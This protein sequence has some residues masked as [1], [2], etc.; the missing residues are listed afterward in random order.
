VNDEQYAAAIAPEIDRVRI[1]I[2]HSIRDHFGPLMLAAG[3]PPA[4]G[5]MLGML[6]NLGPDRVVSRAAVDR[7]FI[8]QA[9]G[10]VDTALDELAAAGVVTHSETD[11]ALTA[12]GAEVIDRMYAITREIV[13]EMWRD[14]THDFGELHTI[15]AKAMDAAA[16]TGGL[17]YSLMAPL[18]EPPGATPTTRFAESLTPLRFHR[19]DAHIA[20]W[21]SAGLTVERAQALDD[22]PLK[23][24]IEAD[25]NA[26]AAL[27]YAALTADERAILLDALRTLPIVAV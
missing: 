19:F 22:G 11:V 23:E 13:G 10:S 5:Q 12:R 20:A 24:R 3:V 14:V 16:Q 2:A 21:M 9:A 4:A 1:A 15:T 6:R 8:Y 25:T 7:V 17:G 18:Y 27:P 26:R